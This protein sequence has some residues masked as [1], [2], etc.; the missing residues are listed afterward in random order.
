[1]FWFTI[2]SQ[3]K[4]FSILSSDS[5]NLVMT[6]FTNSAI[7][8]NKIVFNRFAYFEIT[9]IDVIAVYLLLIFLS[10]IVF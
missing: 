7:A 9:E 1:M 8:S 10:S 4:I 6:K 3:K 2:Y 5:S